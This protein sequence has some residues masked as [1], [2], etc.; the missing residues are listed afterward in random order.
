M[1]DSLRLSDNFRYVFGLLVRFLTVIGHLPLPPRSACPI[2]YGY[3]TSSD[4]SVLRLSDSLRLSDNFRYVFGL[5]VRFFAV[6]GHLQIRLCSACPILN[7][8][9]TTSDTS[10]VCLSDSLRLS[11]NFRFNCTLLVR[12]FAVIGHLPM[13]AKKGCLQMRQPWL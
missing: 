13:R 8:Y 10:S 4:T 7:S 5:L 6:I 9:R 3:R 11:D 12:F 2:L 1:S